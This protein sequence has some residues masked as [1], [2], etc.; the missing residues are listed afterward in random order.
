MGFV[1]NYSAPGFTSP[2][3]FLSR[4][5]ALNPIGAVEVLGASDLAAGPHE[6]R[7]MVS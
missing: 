4:R 6:P 7:H 2:T 5:E 1:T 3:C